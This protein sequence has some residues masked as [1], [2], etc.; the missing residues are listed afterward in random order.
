MQEL[1]HDSDTQSD[2]LKRDEMG[3]SRE[4]S[5]PDSE[6]QLYGR[7][8]GYS[9]TSDDVKICLIRPSPLRETSGIQQQQQQ[10]DSSEIETAK[11]DTFLNMEAN[12]HVAESILS[13]KP[14]LPDVIPTQ[15]S[16]GRDLDSSHQGLTANTREG[17]RRRSGQP[18]GGDGE[19]PGMRR[20]FSSVSFVQET[21]VSAHNTTSGCSSPQR[22]VSGHQTPGTRSR[23]Q[24]G[25]Q[26]PLSTLSAIEV[27]S[28][29]SVGE[30]GV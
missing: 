20:A 19:R 18:T 8:S 26:T 11:D 6:L 9:Q 13:I 28:R 25:R 2:R 24:S 29:G 22:N 30:E 15:M 21:H 17:I 16:V 7:P 12:D 4:P 3:R 1:L 23:Q 14:P 10:L 27:S 5:G